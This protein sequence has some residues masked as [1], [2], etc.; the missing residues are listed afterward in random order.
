MGKLCGNWCLKYVWIHANFDWQLQTNDVTD[1]STDYKTPPEEHVISPFG[2]RQP[3]CL[4]FL[5]VKCE[6]ECF[7]LR[8]LRNQAAWKESVC[9]VNV[10]R[11]FLCCITSDDIHKMCVICLGAEH[12][13]SALK[14]AGYVHCDHFTVKKLHSYLALRKGD[15]PHGS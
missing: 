11:P 1:A 7:S 2:F 4:K 14:G 10:S 8:L 12:A 6:P 5:L 15:V 9:L 3:F 13:R